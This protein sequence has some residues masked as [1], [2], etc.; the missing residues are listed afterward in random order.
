MQAMYSMASEIHLRGVVYVFAGRTIVVADWDDKSG[1]FPF[2]S[3]G[4]A[5]VSPVSGRQLGQ[6]WTNLYCSSDSHYSMSNLVLVCKDFQSCHLIGWQ[7]SHLRLRSHVIKSLLTS[8]SFSNGLL[9]EGTKP[10]PEPAVVTYH[11]W[12]MLTFTCEQF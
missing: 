6:R 11:Q 10:L 12:G 2:S 9:P 4:W 7:D 8:M 5:N 3:V 1:P